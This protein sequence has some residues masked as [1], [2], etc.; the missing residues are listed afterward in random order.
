MNNK[1]KIITWIDPFEHQPLHGL[2]EYNNELVYF[3]TKEHGHSVTEKEYT[4]EIHDI[5]KTY[6]N[7]PQDGETIYK[8]QFYT[9][10]K[11]SDER[12]VHVHKNNICNIYRPS[13]EILTEIRKYAYGFFDEDDKYHC[14]D[15]PE[16]IKLV[17]EYKKSGKY[18]NIIICKYIDHFCNLPLYSF[19]LL[20]L[21]TF[22]SMYNVYLLE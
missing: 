21:F 22:D 16:G 13:P 19:E 5:I 6:K 11:Y 15:D 18:S 20:G 1:F 4:K 3:D 17:E 9:I 2:A 12:N 14:Y 8:D 10:I 7:S